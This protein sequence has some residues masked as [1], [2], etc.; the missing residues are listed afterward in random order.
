MHPSIQSSPT[1]SFSPISVSRLLKKAHYLP[2]TP[3]TTSPCLMLLCLWNQSN[4]VSTSNSNTPNKD[5]VTIFSHCFFILYFSLCVCT[6]ISGSFLPV[7][8]FDKHSLR[9]LFTFA[10]DCPPSRPD[11]LVVI[12]SMLSSAPIPVTN[13]R[14]QAAV[15]KVGFVCYLCWWQLKLHHIPECKSFNIQSVRSHIFS[16]YI[17]W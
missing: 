15:P 13:I 3:T 12:I 8:V 11:V 7:T 5:T 9:V 16:L 4:L 14:F 17:H 10:R 1:P 6:Y 2:L